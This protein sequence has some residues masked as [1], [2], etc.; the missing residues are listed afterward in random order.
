MDT[1]R[2]TRFGVKGGYGELLENFLAI[3]ASWFIGQLTYQTGE[4][5]M[6]HLVNRRPRWAEGWGEDKLQKDCA[7]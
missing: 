3:K 6:T 7:I 2:E 1:D 4:Q 5:L